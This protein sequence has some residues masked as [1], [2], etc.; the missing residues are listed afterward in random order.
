M[1]ADDAQLI[2]TPLHPL[3]PG[4]AYLGGGDCFQMALESAAKLV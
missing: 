4:Y 1:R 3:E 2:S